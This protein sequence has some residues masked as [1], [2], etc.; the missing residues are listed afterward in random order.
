[1][2]H[3]ANEKGIALIGAVAVLMI[4]SLMG[5]VVVSLVGTES[6]SALHQA[7][8]LDA[9]WVAETGAHRALTY[10]SREDGNCTDITGGSDF[11]TISV[12]G[13]K[14]TVTADLFNPSPSAINDGDGITAADTTITV[15]DT[16]GFA[17]YGRIAI[18]S[19]L[20]NYTGISG[21]DFTGAQRGVDG[22]TA[23]THA[24]NTAVSQYQCSIISI[25]TILGGFGDAK[26]TV[27]A[28]VQ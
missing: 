27:E 12:G 6:Y 18:E 20:I 9:Y 11:T 17:P 7:Q 19:E 21:N 25:A 5:A 26:R 10:L 14:F 15:D 4:L 13:G 22:T 8:S 1:M 3:V 24:D 23:A 2:R 28:V 16:T